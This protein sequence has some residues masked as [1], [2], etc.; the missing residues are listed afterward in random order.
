MAVRPIRIRL[1]RWAG[2]FGP[3]QVKIPCGQ[4]SLTR[5][6]ILDAMDQE[7][8]DLAVELEVREW[9]TEWWRPLLRGGWHPPVVQVEG[10]TI[11]QGGAL[12]RGVLSQA[13]IEAHAAC[14]P[15]AGNHLFGKPGCPH[16]QRAK[17]LLEASG[18]DYELHDVIDQPRDL[19]ELLARVKSQLSPRTTLTVPQ[20]WLEGRYVGGAD[21]LQRILPFS[22]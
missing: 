1:Y 2:S 7:L 5:D 19:Y 21:E 16:C 17:E 3:F 11:S 20:I 10:R 12:N 6:I 8:G 18:N 15:L 13:V 14:N 9:L 4:C 22:R